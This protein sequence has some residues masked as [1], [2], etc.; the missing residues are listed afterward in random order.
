MTNSHWIGWLKE[1]V[2]R[3]SG[4]CPDCKNPLL[5]WCH[6]SDIIPLHPSWQGQW[7]TTLVSSKVISSSTFWTF[8]KSENMF[9]GWEN[10]SKTVETITIVFV[11]FMAVSRPVKRFNSSLKK[12]FSYYLLYHVY[13]KN[14]LCWNNLNEDDSFRK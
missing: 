1:P 5:I 11:Y 2:R 4:S 7:P 10:T 12:M 3:W 13:I 6:Q 8:S 14:Q 9:S